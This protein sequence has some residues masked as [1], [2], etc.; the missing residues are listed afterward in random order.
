MAPIVIGTRATPLARIQADLVARRLG[1]LGVDTEVRA[2]SSQGDRSLG[3]SFA[4]AKGVFTGELAAAL[5]DGSVDIVVHSLK[6]LP[7][8]DE[9]D[10]VI[11][12]VPE[13]E[14]PFDLLLFAPDLKTAG[15][16]ETSEPTAELATLLDAREDAAV[17][18]VAAAADA[19]APLP[20]GAHLGTSSPRRQA[21]ALAVRP[22]LVCC[23][24]RGSVGRRL[25]WL[26]SGAIDALLAAEAGVLRLA[27]SGQLEAPDAAIRG[28]RLDLRSWPCAPGQ[29]A[30]AVQIL[31]GGRLD[32]HP[33][34]A[35]LDHAPSRDA[36][37]AERSLLGRL[38]GGCL[39][40][41]GAW[42]D[43]RAAGEERAVL[44]EVHALIAA[45]DWRESAGVGEAPRVVHAAASVADGAVD[46]DALAGRIERGL[47]EVAPDP[48]AGAPSVGLPDLIVTSGPATVQ[49]LT[50]RLDPAIR[51]AALPATAVEVLDTPWPADRI[52]LNRPR[53]QWPWL[54]VSSPTA[55]RVTAKRALR[56]PAWG[57][58][59]WCALGEGTAR[60]LLAAGVPPNLA[61]RA[62]G[63]G[64]FARY[65]ARVLDPH[66]PLFVPH[67]ARGG[68]S[69]V[70]ALEAAGRQVTAWETYTVHPNAELDW[71]QGWQAAHARVLFTA[72][73]AVSAFV[74][75]GLD[76][77]GSCWAIGAAT[78]AALRSAGAGNVKCAQE[79][80]AAGIERLWLDEVG[81]QPKANR[82]PR[83]NG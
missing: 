6:D 7:V 80:T 39:R 9:D 17:R 58:L 26:Q 42:A 36:A 15:E 67:S 52:D 3:G 82:D 40:P 20:P 81:A 33:A 38:G 55:A 53:R 72:P 41:F 70:E 34:M 14:R 65:A 48:A 54:L 79:P 77:P 25:E 11:A 49:R 10:L 30:L 73:S 35:A 56:E 21:G 5:R 18:N 69:L 4:Q 75:S 13:R 19:F 37:F 62:S 83:E 66:C 31:R 59:P 1:A 68:G 23:A 71:P 27:R 43:A 32:G 44:N 8:E 78:A 16:G 2:M 63:G 47:G 50:R 64:E 57:R 45:D 12:A 76:W 28:Y 24:V 46:L 22:D 51:I 74:A 29:G 61:A 60:A